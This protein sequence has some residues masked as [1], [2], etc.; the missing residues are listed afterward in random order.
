MTAGR[1]SSDSKTAAFLAG[2]IFVS[3]VAGAILLF[4]SP[5]QNGVPDEKN[6]RREVATKSPDRAALAP[7]ELLDRIDHQSAGPQT[8]T[9]RLQLE[10]LLDE[11][12]DEEIAGF[13]ERSHGHL[14]RMQRERVYRALFTRWI[15]ND[16]E[17]AMGAYVGSRVEEM[18]QP[19][20]HSTMTLLGDLTRAWLKE[21]PKS[22][23]VWLHLNWQDG[24][25]AVNCASQFNS[26]TLLSYR[27]VIGRELIDH[28]RKEEGIEAALEYLDGFDLEG[29]VSML[30]SLGGLDFR[31][32]SMED[33]TKIHESYQTLPEGMARA[34]FGAVFW[35]NWSISSPEEVEKVIAGLTPGERLEARLSLLDDLSFGWRRKR[36]SEQVEGGT[37]ELLTDVETAAV[38]AALEAGFERDEAVAWVGR[39]YIEQSDLSSLKSLGEWLDLNGNSLDLDES[40]RDRRREL[41]A[42]SDAKNYWFTL[43]GSLIL[44]NHLKNPTERLESSRNAFLQ[45]IEFNRDHAE[46]AMHRLKIGPDLKE[47]FQ[48]ILEGK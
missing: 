14:T 48:R 9:G 13:V 30:T 36:P 47:E 35:K 15:A 8:L 38:A 16:P 17:A 4:Q 2:G 44:A 31:G 40:L 43:G 5:T 11:I 23:A 7:Q 3:V 25:M 26:D 32:L 46:L 24:G 21:N 33:N 1:F 28:L 29:K 22:A 45:L 34:K 12:P 18:V 37:R 10:K 41:L 27:D 6:I 39:Q 42:E 20:D 19:F